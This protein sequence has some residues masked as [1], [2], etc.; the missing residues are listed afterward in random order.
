MVA[1]LIDALFV[2]IVDH[3]VNRHIQ[4]WIASMLLLSG[5]IGINVWFGVRGAPQAHRVMLIIIYKNAKIGP[6]W[7]P[8]ITTP[9]QHGHLLFIVNM[10]LLNGRIV[11]L[12][13]R[14]V[15]PRTLLV[16]LTWW[17]SLLICL[18]MASHLGSLAMLWRGFH[19]GRRIVGVYHQGLD[20]IVSFGAEA[21]GVAALRTGDRL[22]VLHHGLAGDQ[23]WTVAKFARRSLILIISWH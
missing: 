13:G 9:T 4:D 21:C 22:L 3:H 8:R 18:V 2:W 17:N 20:S 7:D 1:G 16:L 10:M 5:L 23:N 14:C 19:L 12:V 11:C 6:S 15:F